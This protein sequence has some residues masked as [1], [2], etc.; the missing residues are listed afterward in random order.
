V[1]IEQGECVDRPIPS[2]QRRDATITSRC[3]MSTNCR[4]RCFKPDAGPEPGLRMKKHGGRGWR[5]NL[6]PRPGLLLLGID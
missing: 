3:T 5:L 1:T 2:K 6:A 4:T